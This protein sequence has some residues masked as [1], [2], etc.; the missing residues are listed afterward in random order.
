MQ[1]DDDS[2]TRQPGAKSFSAWLISSVF[3]S[4]AALA[5]TAVVIPS[6]YG[7]DYRDSSSVWG[8][9]GIADILVGVTCLPVF[10]LVHLIAYLLLRSRGQQLILRSGSIAV[11]IWLALLLPAVLTAW[12]ARGAQKVLRAK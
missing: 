7:V 12:Q 8:L 5:I 6:I 4:I 10:L 11:A 3:G 1:S 2:S 9:S